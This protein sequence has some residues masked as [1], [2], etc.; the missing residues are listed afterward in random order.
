[1]VHCRSGPIPN[2]KSE[3]PFSRLYLS[4]SLNHWRNNPAWNGNIAFTLSAPRIPV[5]LFFLLSYFRGQEENHI[6]SILCDFCVCKQPQSWQTLICFHLETTK[7]T[8]YMIKH[9]KKIFTVIS[10]F[11]PSS[12]SFSGSAGSDS[13][14]FMQIKIVIKFR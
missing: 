2:E 7:C 9:T 6:W 1:M 3:G 13:K 14:W 11:L 10:C 5:F 4:V 8:L 12:S